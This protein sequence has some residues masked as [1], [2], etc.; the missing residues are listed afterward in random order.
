MT[1]SMQRFGRDATV[2]AV[3]HAA[4]VWASSAPVGQRWRRVAELHGAVGIA[5]LAYG[6]PLL[7][8]VQFVDGLTGPLLPQPLRQDCDDVALVGQG[9]LSAAAVD[10]LME[11]L[12]PSLSPDDIADWSMPRLSAE[13]VQGWL[14]GSCLRPAAR[15][16]TGEPARRSSPTPPVRWPR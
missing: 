13:K 16:A 10:L 8:L 9:Q 7:P 5:H 14:Y 11:N 1:V 12:A 2:T 3:T 15:R 4:N 6:E